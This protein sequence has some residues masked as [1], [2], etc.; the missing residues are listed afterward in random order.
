[1]NP[2][3]FEQESLPN[4]STRERFIEYM[5]EASRLRSVTEVVA[6][7]FIGALSLGSESKTVE[8]IG[9]TLGSLFFVSGIF[10]PIISNVVSEYFGTNTSDTIPKVE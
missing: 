5:S 7:L 9:V 10:D 4:S 2:S 8:L 6:G 3:S 1:M